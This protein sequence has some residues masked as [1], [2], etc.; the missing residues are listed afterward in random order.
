MY[1]N[2][3]NSWSAGVFVIVQED[4]VYLQPGLE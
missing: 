4:D 2:C 1:I 3:A